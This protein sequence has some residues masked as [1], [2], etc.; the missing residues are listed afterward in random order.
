MLP[1]CKMEN[2]QR[3]FLNHFGIQ[4]H[5]LKIPMLYTKGEMM[6]ELIQPVVVKK[7]I[8]DG[9]FLI[10]PIFFGDTDVI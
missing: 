4:Q 6:E 3:I 1:A 2:A 7:W 9:W 5:C 8:I 10:V